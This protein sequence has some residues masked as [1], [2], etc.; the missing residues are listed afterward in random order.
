MPAAKWKAWGEWDGK[1]QYNV[2]PIDNIALHAKSK[3]VCVDISFS[4]IEKQRH[5][6][7]WKL[8]SLPAVNFGL[9]A[10]SEQWVVNI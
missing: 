10:I 6:S 1:T 5:L 3:V 4:N 2:I 9:R 8:D 7:Y